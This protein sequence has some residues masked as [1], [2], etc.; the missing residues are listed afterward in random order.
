MCVWLGVLL[1]CGEGNGAASRCLAYEY[2]VVVYC[3]MGYMCMIQ[4]NDSIA[5]YTP[6]KNSTKQL[7]IK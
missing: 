5:Q 7:C 6:L 1:C 3:V 2:F 4:R